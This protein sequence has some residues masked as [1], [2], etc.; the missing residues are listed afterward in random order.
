M[1]AEGL[2]KYSSLE[3]LGSSTTDHPVTQSFSSSSAVMIAACRTSVPNTLLVQFLIDGSQ[4]P[5]ISLNWGSFH[6]RNFVSIRVLAK[7]KPLESGEKLMH[8]FSRVRLPILSPIFSDE[9]RD[10][11][12][13]LTNITFFKQLLGALV[14]RTLHIPGQPPLI[15]HSQSPRGIILPIRQYKT[16]GYRLHFFITHLIFKFLGQRLFL[17]FG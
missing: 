14:S 3:I 17:W 16:L 9:T 5:W 13:Q 12:V 10:L 8:T 4:V 2:I 11:A 6:L 7:H 15:E 1:C